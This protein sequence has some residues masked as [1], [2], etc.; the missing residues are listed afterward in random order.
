MADFGVPSV[1]RLKE[2]F[3]SGAIIATAVGVLALAFVI[4]IWISDNGGLVRQPDSDTYQ[5]VVLPGNQVY[6]GKLG[7]LGYSFVT[8]TDVYYEPGRTGTE[9]PAPDQVNLV[10]LGEGPTDI[11]K[12]EAEMQVAAEKIISWEDLKP[13]SKIVKA[14]EENK[15]K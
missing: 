13:D 5:I 14:I 1:S 6:V 3:T 7:P 12:P 4:G 2:D 8:L 15:K 11:H 10:Q 9:T